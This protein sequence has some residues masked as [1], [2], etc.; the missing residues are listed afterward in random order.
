MNNIIVNPYKHSLK[1]IGSVIEFISPSIYECVY[2]SHTY[3]KDLWY[4]DLMKAK[5]NALSGF[6]EEIDIETIN[7]CNGE[8][9]FCPV[10]RNID[11][12]KF[13][14]M[15]EELFKN[16]IKQLH[17]I[18]YSGII[19]PFCNNE[20]LIDNRIFGFIEYIKRQA[21]RARIILNTNGT[22]LTTPKFNRLIPNLDLLII[23]NYN[24]KLEMHPNI[25]E[26]YD[27][28]KDDPKY[29]NKVQIMLRKQNEILT[30]RSGQATNRNKTRPLRSPCIYPYMQMS[31]RS[32]GMV[33]SCCN[34]A[35]GK[36][37]MGNL[38]TQSII[39]V[40][41][42]KLYRDFRAEMLKGRRN[43]AVCRDCDSIVIPEK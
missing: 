10:N 15:S 42:S 12:R 29:I 23:D 2:S 14:L 39:D 19:C 24:D 34:D 21:P 27:I 7:R 35:L 28:C 41:N 13:H 18:H 31:V 9:S 20:P 17:D 4:K 37:I 22:L 6:I 38:N 36:G 3:I 1:G 43:L 32:D 40:W 5:I 11:T 8:C 16:I 26:I 30:T 25:R 33:I